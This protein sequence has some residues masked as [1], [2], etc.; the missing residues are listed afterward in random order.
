MN[1][2]FHLSGLQVAYGARVILDIAD[3]HIRN[4]ATTAIIGPNG[5]GKSTLLKALLGGHPCRQLHCL[6]QDAAQV[7]QLGKIAWVGQHE[8]FATPLTVL[9]YVLLGRYPHLGWLS[10]LSARDI[11]YAE[12]LL[13]EF[14][15][16]AFAG[17]RLQA[18][19]GGEK[20]RAA[21]VRA[22]MQ[23]T[24]ILLLDEPNNHLDIK[25]QHQLMQHLQR[26]QRHKDVSSVIVLHDLALA[27]NYCEEVI[28]L[29]Q[30]QVIAQ[31]QPHEVMTA[32]HLLR[33]YQWPI[34]PEQ[35]NGAW[36]FDTF[37]AAV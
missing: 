22:L 14:E 30:G 29:A 32:E 17:K 34:T 25:H 26:Y 2:L 1:D 36:Y 16:A 5:A 35:R 10:R 11:T 9:E 19:S 15:L 31:G 23:D 6:G 18:L 3:L 27:A 28:L 24:N 20:Q 4:H 8:T 12:T 33:A 7:L 13:A 21:L 37:Q